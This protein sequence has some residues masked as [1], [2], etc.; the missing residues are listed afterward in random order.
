VTQLRQRL[1]LNGFLSGEQNDLR[2]TLSED[3]S[4]VLAQKE[5]PALMHSIQPSHLR[6]SD[7]VSRHGQRP[8]GRGC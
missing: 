2:N 3:I 1:S 7:I 8:D 4:S 6:R 5:G